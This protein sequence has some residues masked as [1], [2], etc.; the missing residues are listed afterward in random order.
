M[1][2]HLDILTEE[3]KPSWSQVL[4]EVLSKDFRSL[5]SVLVSLS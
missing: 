2:D 3:M 5:R 1:E 4:E